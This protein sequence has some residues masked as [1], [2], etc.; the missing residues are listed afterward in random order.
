MIEIIKDIL[1]YLPN[2]TEEVK[3]AK[4]KYQLPSNWK[5]FKNAIK[6]S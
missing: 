6:L 2:K 3:T 1:Q 5:E 4:G